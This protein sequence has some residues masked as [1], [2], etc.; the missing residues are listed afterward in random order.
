MNPTRLRWLITFSLVVHTRDA[1]QLLGSRTHFDP[2]PPTV[3]HG[4]TDHPIEWCTAITVRHDEPLLR[5]RISASLQQ[6]VQ[7]PGTPAGLVPP[8]RSK[9]SSPT[10]PSGPDPAYWSMC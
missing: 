9:A 6:D 8:I 5:C 10:H 3:H 4:P 2:Q 1:A 7:P